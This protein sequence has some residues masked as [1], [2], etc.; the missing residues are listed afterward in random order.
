MSKNKRKVITLKPEIDAD[1]INYLEKC[2]NFQ[3]YI[4]KL[5]RYE[6]NHNVLKPNKRPSIYDVAREKLRK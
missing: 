4:K 3:E 6:M 1:I 2:D 5:I